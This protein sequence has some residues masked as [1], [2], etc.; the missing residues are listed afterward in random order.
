M[1][2]IIWNSYTF[3]GLR[4][5]I[6]SACQIIMNRLSDLVFFLMNVWRQYSFPPHSL[7]LLRE[8]NCMSCFIFF[9]MVKVIYNTQ[10]KIQASIKKKVQIP[11]ILPPRT[12]HFW[13][14]DVFC[15]LH[16]SLCICADRNIELK[17]YFFNIFKVLQTFSCA[18]Y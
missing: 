15:F 2:N 9:L 11:L 17:Y 7:S 14:V 12:N 4:V 13:S 3:Q 6:N 5:L 10:I 1:L 16:F 8:E 18:N